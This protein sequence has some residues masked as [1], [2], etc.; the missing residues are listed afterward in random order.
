MDGSTGDR[1][2]IQGKQAEEAVQR[3]LHPRK[4][5][6]SVGNYPVVLVKSFRR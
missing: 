1:A 6:V 5:T 4:Y 2:Q 3:S